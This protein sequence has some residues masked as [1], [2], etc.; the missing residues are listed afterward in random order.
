MNSFFSFSLMSLKIHLIKDL[1]EFSFAFL[2]HEENPFISCVTIIWESC[3]R[4][5][6][7]VSILYRS[8]SKV[9]SFHILLGIPSLIIDWY[10]IYSF[11]CKVKAFGSFGLYHGL[12]NA[13]KVIQGSISI[14]EFYI[15]PHKKFDENIMFYETIVYM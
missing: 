1:T 12:L 8:P 15:I 13:R 14:T 11:W 9:T 7:T 4:C 6:H 3:F 10:S 5:P 2:Y